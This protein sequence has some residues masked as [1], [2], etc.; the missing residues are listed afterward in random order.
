[1]DDEPMWAPD[2][3]V[4]LTPGS[5]ITI[6]ETAN[7]FAI[8]GN[9]LTLIKGNQFDGRTKTDP[10]KHIHE[11][12]KMCDMFKYRDT[13]NEV[14]TK[15]QSRSKQ[16]N[17]ND[18]NLLIS[19]EEEAKFMKTFRRTHSGYRDYDSNRNNWRSSGRTDYNRDNYQS[20]SNDKPD[21]RK[22]LSNFIKAQHLTNF[23]VKDTL[24][25]L[26]NKLETTTKNHQA[27][28]KNLK[29]KFD[30]LADKQSGQLS[31]SLP[32]NTQPNPKVSSSKPFQPPQA[33]NKHVNAVFTQSANLGASI[34]LMLYFLYAK[35]SLETLRPTKIIV[36]LADQSFQYPVGIDENMLVEVGKFTFPADFV[37]LE[38]EED[39][40]QLNLGVG[41]ERMIFHIDFAMKHSYSNDDTCCSIDVIDEILEEDF[42][43]LLNEHSEIL[44]SIEGT[45]LEE[46]LFAKFDEFMAMTA[47]ENSKSKSNI[48]EPPFEKITFNTDYKIKISL[49]EPLMDLEVRICSEVNGDVDGVPDFSTVVAQQIQN[50]LPTIVAQV[51]RQ[52]T[53]QG[54][55]QVGRQ[56]TYQGNGRN[57]NAD[58]IN[59]NIQ[60]N[61]RNVIENNDRM[62]T[63]KEFLACHPKEYDGKDGAIV[64]TRWIEKM[65]SI[66][67]MSGCRDNQKAV[68]IVGTLTDEAIRN[69]SIKKNPKKRGNRGE[70][71]KDRNGSHD[72]KKTRAR[73]AFAT[74]TNPVRRENT[75]TTPKCTTCN[76]YHPPKAPCHTCFNCNHP[77]HLAKDFR[78]TSRNVNPINARNPTARACYECGSTDHLKAACP[79]LN[80]A[81]MLGETMRTKLWLLMGA[82]VMGIM[83][84]R[85]VEGHLCWEQRR[86][87]R[88]RTS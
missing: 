22:Q 71:S 12:L 39:S 51:G 11:F 27:S 4:A 69:G 70:P 23:F 57:Q 60:G 14:Y 80:Q 52:G 33:R 74:T 82:K 77:G 13:E 32:S 36:R 65:E 81:Q 26:K 43:T 24:I 63:Y 84:I 30:R 35:L 10:H 67:D 86:L 53:D 17:L 58:A 62:G 55:A 19:R 47:D 75:G 79:R 61:V 48:E 64:Y 88:T 41:T 68:Q 28:I 78:L 83:V 18:D 72:N 42:D 85:H 40:K 76:F 45:I 3:V 15:F 59:D 54:N 2:R 38:M 8:K 87:T 5:A 37:I 1:M 49:E 46:K 66:H 34:Y 29:S 44:H 6:P 31:R 20:H 21:L 9:H 50:L 25:D 56:G 16:P 7:E 73:N